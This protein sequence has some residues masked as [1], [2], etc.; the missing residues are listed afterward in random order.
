MPG[1]QGSIFAARTPRGQEGKGALLCMHQ[2]PVGCDQVRRTISVRLADNEG[3]R[4]EA[5]ILVNRMYSWRGYGAAHQ[6]MP[7]ANSVTFTASS[8]DDMIGTLTLGVD[9]SDGL[10]A[11]QTFKE[12]LDVFRSTPGMR[13]CELTKFAVDP[14]TRSKPALAAL[15][16]VIFIY[17]SERFNCTDLFIEVHPRHIRFY[18]VMLGFRRVGDPKIDNSVT[19]WPEGVPVQLMR[20]E[21]SEIRRQIQKHAGRS[22]KAGHCLYPYFFSPEEERGIA[23]RVAALA[24]A[25]AKAIA[26]PA[27]PTQ[28]SSMPQHKL[29]S[30]AAS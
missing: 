8:N 15:F 21:V 24:R 19:W 23:S 9:S 11:D 6:L 25:D 27:L 3:V 26:V 5:S 7:K 29:R 14:T 18:E 2:V 1:S 13:L 12:E 22:S 30:V 4:N 10:A 16:H 17:G 20:L 28:Q